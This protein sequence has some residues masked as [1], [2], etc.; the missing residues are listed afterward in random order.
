MHRIARA[1]AGLD[2]ALWDAPE[3]FTDAIPEAY[4]ASNPAQLRVAFTIILDAILAGSVSRT[5][6]QTAPSS[7]AW[8][9]TYE[10]KATFEVGLVGPSWKGFITRDKL[11]DTNDDGIL[12]QVERLWFGP[13]QWSEAQAGDFFR[14]LPAWDSRNLLTIIKDPRSKGFIPTTLNPNY[15]LPR[16]EGMAPLEDGLY[17][18]RLP[19][20]PDNSMLCLKDP[21]G[22]GHNVLETII[23]QYVSGKPFTPTDISGIRF[24]LPQP[25]GPHLGDIFHANPVVVTPPA[26]LTPDFKYEQYFRANFDR[27]TM[28]YAGTNDGFLHAFVAQDNKDD[29]VDEDGKELW[30]FIPNNLLAKIEKMRWGAHQFFVDSSPVVRDVYFPSI[31]TPNPDQPGDC[32]KDSSD[33]CLMGA[34]RTVLVTG[35]REGGPA[36]FALDVTDPESPGYLWEYRTTGLMDDYAPVQCRNSKIQ[37]WSEPIIGEVWLKKANTTNP[38]YLTKSVVVFPGGYVPP[39][40]LRHV[41]TCIDIVE[42]MIGGG[43]LHVLDIETGELLKRFGFGA[44]AGSEMD[45]EQ[46][47]QWLDE[48][49][50]DLAA[51]PTSN[52][53]HWGVG[54][55]FGTSDFEWNNSPAGWMCSEHRHHI[56]TSPEAPPEL[57]DPAFCD[58]IS[59]V[60][61]IVYQKSCCASGQ[62][63]ISKC[64][65]FPGNSLSPHSCSYLFREFDD[66]RIESW[67]TTQGCSDTWTTEKSSFHLQLTDASLT[68]SMGATPAVYNPNQGEFITRMFG[69]TNQGRI[70]RMNLANAQYDPTAPEGDK[71]EPYTGDNTKNWKL[72]PDGPW[73]DAFDA[74]EVLAGHTRRPITVPPDLAVDYARDLVVF[75]GTGE[76]DNLEYNPNLNLCRKRRALQRRHRR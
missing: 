26:A 50:A 66:G 21:E 48:F 41:S 3:D 63:T 75:F 74:T 35:E 40:T 49:Y 52:W 9:A 25:F 16:Y 64:N 69:G 42:M 53:S 4:F 39:F 67:L 7:T 33:N 47:Y 19:F 38:E 43:S 8:E 61:D 56:S 44:G 58:E 23:K 28:I 36:Y 2:R 65:N 27:H 76:I 12:E 46:M 30:A 70:Y 29:G 55:S 31:P 37:T 62:Q 22:M 72:E 11:E 20:T 15:R 45:L 68:E 60:G 1:G 54:Q 13:P 17:P 24:S 71:I 51:N 5:S 57:L 32:L 10:Y 59:N 73:Y 14:P 6:A 18:F 34:Y